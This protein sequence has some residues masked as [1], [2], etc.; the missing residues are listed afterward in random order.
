MAGYWKIE[1]EWVTE[2]GLN[3][4]EAILL[5]DI[6][7]WPSC[8]IEERANR[9]GVTKRSV[10]R[11][12]ETLKSCDKMSQE[13]VTKLHTQSV[14]MSQKVC[15]NVTKSV[16]KCHIPPHPPII[17]EQVEE[18][19]EIGLTNVSPA[20]PSSAVGEKPKEKKKKKYTEEQSK[21]HG[22][23]KRIFDEEWLKVHGEN[24]YWTPAQ[25][26]SLPKIAAQIKFHMP[27]EQKNSL[28]I[29]SDNFRIFIQHILKDLPWYRENGTP[30]VI[31]SKFNE[32]Y[33]Q[34][35]NG[36][37]ST[38]PTNR[39]Q[40]KYSAEFLADIAAGLA[41]GSQDIG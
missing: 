18:K 31:A 10:Y 4:N 20:E 37:A 7:A 19:E 2:W 26:A 36:T 23:M 35:K 16:T 25:M 27:E 38:K 32:I 5:A 22:E 8:S 14:K 34:L 24:F 6:I 11:I 40:P 41:G 21:M 9:V 28:N 3:G 12:I 30:Q 17:E 13:F 15:K 39:H 33:S 29:I 1:K